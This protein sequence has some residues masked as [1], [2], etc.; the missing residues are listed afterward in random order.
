MERINCK[1]LLLMSLM[2]VL[3]VIVAVLTN[4]RYFYIQTIISGVSNTVL[5]ETCNLPFSLTSLEQYQRYNLSFNY[6]YHYFETIM[7]NTRKEVNQWHRNQIKTFKVIVDIKEKENLVHLSV[8]IAN[9][10]SFSIGGASFKLNF[11][12]N[13]FLV[14]YSI[15]DYFNGTY[16]GCY[17]VPKDC[18]TL[19]IKMLFVNFAAY[20]DL[21]P[22]P[23][24]N[25][26]YTKSWC[27]SHN[28]TS[29]LHKKSTICKKVTHST[30]MWIRDKEILKY[31]ERY[32]TIKDQKSFLE[33]KKLNYTC[34]QH[35]KSPSAF[36]WFWKETGQDCLIQQNDLKRRWKKCCHE[37]HSI[38]L[39]GDSHT[40]G[41]YSYISNILGAN[42]LERKTR[43]SNQHYKK[44]SLSWI[45]YNWEV[46]KA[47]EMFVQKYTK[48]IKEKKISHNKKALVLFGFGS[49]S[50]QLHN[51][52]DYFKT[53]PIL[54]P[55]IR[56]MVHLSKVSN[57]KW[58]YITR[59]S[60]WDNS[61]CICNIYNQEQKIPNIFNV[62]AINEYTI[63]TFKELGLQFEIFDFYGLTVHRNNE[64]VDVCHY[65]VGGNG[66]VLG[67]VG[68]SATDV[69]LTQLCPNH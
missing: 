1:T 61:P 55:T 18:F 20:Y 38:H 62:A 59:P 5:K 23:L 26:I 17:L 36:A 35:L 39:I 45:T 40:R 11:E 53:F 37:Y 31:S 56:Q 33:E 29:V 28:I 2:L 58:M 69:L 3:F 34:Y 42:V 68:L 65:V 47:L 25:I 7:F 14:S 44:V 57:I 54:K 16:H 6:G 50:L 10:E 13:H 41:L 19:N 24:P 22:C 32:Y 9:S 67:T 52:S 49:W 64:V 12:G 43:W 15:L 48:I 60:V 21:P 27:P 46:K 63:R 66:S 51:I 30:G 4:V 8:N